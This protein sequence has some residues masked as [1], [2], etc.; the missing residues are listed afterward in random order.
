MTPDDLVEIELIKRLKYRYCRCLDQKRFDELEAVFTED[1]TAAYGGGAV[2]LG[3]RA[4]ILAFLRDALGSEAMLTSHLVSHPE[5]D[6]VGPTEATG[7][8]SLRD[9]VLH[10]DFGVEIK[11]A[12]F[13]E[14][15]YVKVDGAWLI[16][17]TGYKRLYEEL[18]PRSPDA[19]LTAS[20]WGTEGRSSLV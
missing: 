6:L 11:G 20:W 18:T 3:D 9:V 4:A 2:Q 8:W 7:I 16:A 12:S 19:Q 15:R 10:G 5:I 17:H 1:A 13:Y 14:D